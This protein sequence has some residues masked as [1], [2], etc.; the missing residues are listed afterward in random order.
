MPIFAVSGD[1]MVLNINLS[2][3]CR[4]LARSSFQYDV[5]KVF[6]YLV[7]QATQGD[8]GNPLFRDCT[9]HLIPRQVFSYAKCR[10]SSDPLFPSLPPC[11][12]T[13]WFQNCRFLAFAALQTQFW[14]HHRMVEYGVG[15][16]FDFQSE[17]DIRHGWRLSTAKSREG[18]EIILMRCAMAQQFS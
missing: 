1:D 7:P 9:S 5:L 11:V 14:H 6:I 2:W 3:H 13:Q 15:R 17:G 16:L 18:R 8:S 12:V 4:H 10:K